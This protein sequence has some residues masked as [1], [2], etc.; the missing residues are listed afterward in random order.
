M[1]KQKGYMANIKPNATVYPKRLNLNSKYNLFFTKSLRIPR[2]CRSFETISQYDL[3]FKAFKLQSTPLD[4]H[5]K[6]EV[7]VGYE[8]IISGDIILFC[9]LCTRLNLMSVVINSANDFFFFASSQFSFLT[10]VTSLYINL[11]H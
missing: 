8:K 1:N 4:Q 5:N 2:S 9:P 6:L 7:Y 3:G 11:Q 10:K